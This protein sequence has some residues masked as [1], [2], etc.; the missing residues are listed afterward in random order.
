MEEQVD[1]LVGVSIQKCVQMLLNQKLSRCYF[2]SINVRKYELI[3]LLF[4]VSFSNVFQ[5]FVLRGSKM[6][7]C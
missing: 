7:L 3:T 1:V 5:M 4:M 6:V 2:S